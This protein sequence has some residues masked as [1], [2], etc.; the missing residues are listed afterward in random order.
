[1][2][3][4][5]HKRKRSAT[6]A[7]RARGMPG[8]GG[9]W[10]ATVY[11]DSEM[12]RQERTASIDAHPFNHQ[13]EIVVPATDD[14]FLERLREDIEG[15]TGSIEGAC[16]ARVPLTLFLTPEF[17]AKYIRTGT[18]QDSPRRTGRTQYDAPRRSGYR[19]PRRAR[20]AYLITQQGDVPDAGTRRPAKPLCTGGIGAHG[21]SYQR[22]G[23]TIQ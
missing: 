5:T 19:V 12:G 22:T 8:G 3:H 6:R 17:V 9:R 10:I 11:K 21:R 2:P 7:D 15:V 23:R 13:L 1:M 14:A 4:S 18:P 16:I 20:H